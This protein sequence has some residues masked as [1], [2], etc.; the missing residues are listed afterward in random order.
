ME[1]NS[2]LARNVTWLMNQAG[3]NPTSLSAALGEKAPGKPVVPQVT[4]FRIVNAHSESPRNST[5]QPIAAYFG[6][7]VSDLWEHDFE[8]LGMP[9]KQR[10]ADVIDAG[11]DSTDYDAEA[12]DIIRRLQALPIERLGAF[13]WVQIKTIIADHERR[14]AAA[15]KDRPQSDTN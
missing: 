11:R 8:K 1:N 13:T 9:S 3:L 12:Q 10:V 14:A 5:L 4:I 7:A 15:L 2:L 6:V